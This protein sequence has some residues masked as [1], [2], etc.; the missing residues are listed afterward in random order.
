MLSV[1]VCVY[2]AVVTRSLARHTR[3]ETPRVK[4]LGQEARGGEEHAAA[5]GAK[6]RAVGCE[7]SERCE[8][9][10]NQ[11]VLNCLPMRQL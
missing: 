9:S 5:V 10:S 2:T 4:A 3:D 7:A 11:S 6:P 1:C 8:S